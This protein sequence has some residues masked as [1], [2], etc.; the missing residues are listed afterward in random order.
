MAAGSS[1]GYW[2]SPT[3]TT[4]YVSGRL[5]LAVIGAVAQTE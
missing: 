3:V 2:D 4:T 1:L 5:M